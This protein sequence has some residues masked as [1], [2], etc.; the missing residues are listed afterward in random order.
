MAK[1][2]TSLPSTRAKGS[3]AALKP[4]GVSE[5]ESGAFARQMVHHPDR[6]DAGV[7]VRRYAEACFYADKGARIEP[8]RRQCQQINERLKTT[9][10]SIAELE[11]E[12]ARTDQV[13]IKPESEHLPFSEWKPRIQITAIVLSVGMVV[14]MATAI[15][16]IYSN[17]MASN[18]PVFIDAPYLALF[19]ALVAPLTSLAL[20][21]ATSFIKLDRTYLLYAQ[22]LYIATFLVF[23]VWCFLFAQSFSGVANQ[24][25]IWGS[26]DSNDG[27][28]GTALVF[29]MTLLEI[30]VAA[31]LG[32]ALE[33]LAHD[34]SPDRPQTKP[35]WAEQ[36]RNLA[37][38]YK[39]QDALQKALAPLEQ[40]L[41]QLEAERSA[42]VESYLANFAVLC[43]RHTAA[44][45]FDV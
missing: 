26:L 14:S 8:L 32:V 10:V 1:H 21:S 2:P 20:K 17:L 19:I 23:V 37:A 15:A 40:E 11:Q 33:K 24:G 34:Q 42:F 38:L 39:T 45:T 5:Q 35:L 44:T 28:G 13:M 25:D 43:A 27:K 41:H 30:L 22:G 31:C 18:Q 16:N 12:H 3:E 9:S 7:R 6:E 4:R 36:E 29:V